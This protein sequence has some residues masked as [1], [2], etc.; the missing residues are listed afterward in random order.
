MFPVGLATMTSV[1]PSVPH[2][3]GQRTFDIPPGDSDGCARTLRWFIWAASAAI[4][5]CLAL[6]FHGAQV[7][8]AQANGWLVAHAFGL[9]TLTAGGQPTIYFFQASPGHGVSGGLAALVVTP[10][11][12]VLLMLIPLMALFGLLLGLG[13]LKNRNLLLATAVAA[14]IM[15]AINQ[16]RLAMIIGFIRLFGF[17]RGYPISHIYIGSVFAV[18]GFALAIFVFIKIASRDGSH[19]PG[20]TE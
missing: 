2:P 12:S 16:L 17:P 13:R 11:C 8:E 9:N 14:V 3:M 18:F 15:I 1:Q 4:V 6:S 5:A 10:E 7:I 20:S 19:A